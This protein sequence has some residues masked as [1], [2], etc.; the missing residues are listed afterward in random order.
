MNNVM[1]NIKIF[2]P[3]D[4]ES[5]NISNILETINKKI[6]IENSKLSKLNELKKGFMQNMFV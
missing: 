4:I 6:I 3:N 2:L 5:Y 1:S